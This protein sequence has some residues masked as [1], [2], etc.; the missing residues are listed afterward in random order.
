MYDGVGAGVGAG[1]EVQVVRWGGDTLISMVQ[2]RE[3]TIGQALFWQAVFAEFFVGN[4]TRI[5]KL[6]HC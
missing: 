5:S 3:A 4:H 2:G 6:M 1:V